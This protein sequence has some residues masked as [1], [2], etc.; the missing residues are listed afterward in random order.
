[1]L[2]KKQIFILK[3]SPCHFIS[4]TIQLQHPSCCQNK[5]G[6]EEIPP[7]FPA[8]FAVFAVNYESPPPRQIT[9]LYSAYVISKEIEDIFNQSKLLSCLLGFFMTG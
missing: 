1:M 8:L 9:R 6:G 7:N 2:D 3:I 5:E 4:S